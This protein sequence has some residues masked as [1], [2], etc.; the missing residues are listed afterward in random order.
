MA[1]PEETGGVVDGR[2]DGLLRAGAVATLLIALLLVGEI[3]VYAALPRSE[4]TV[5]HL[6]L[7]SDNWLAGLLT[8]EAT[9]GTRA[10]G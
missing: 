6:R 9:V 1:W 3:A 2:W 7:L 4:T 5:E 8:L 10:V